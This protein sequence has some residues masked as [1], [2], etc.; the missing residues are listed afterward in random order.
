PRS[1][2]RFSAQFLTS[3][4]QAIMP[5]AA[6]VPEVSNVVFRRP[7]GVMETYRIP[8]SKTGLPLTTV[9]RYF[10]P[11]FTMAALVRPPR[12]DFDATPPKLPPDS[13]PPAYMQFLARLQN[14]KLP[15][16]SVVGFGAQAPVFAASMPT[17]FVLRQGRLS[18]DPFYS[19]V[20]S[21]H[22]HQ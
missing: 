12:R 8:W 15:D 16:R 22:G 19:G 1:T 17:S 4:P 2:R 18:T 5:H 20:F 21:G 6:D 11:A 10:T 7:D 9:G 13:E 3:R 14:C